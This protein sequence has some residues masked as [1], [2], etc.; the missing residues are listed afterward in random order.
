MLVELHVVVL[1]FG[2]LNVDAAVQVAFLLMSWWRESDIHIGL[3]REA[4]EAK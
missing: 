1:C 4:R 3:V 2:I